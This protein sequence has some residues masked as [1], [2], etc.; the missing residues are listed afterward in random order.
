LKFHK[1][2]INNQYNSPRIAI[3]NSILMKMDGVAP[4]DSRRRPDMRLMENGDWD[5]ANRE[6]SRLE[7]KQRNETRKYLVKSSFKVAR[8]IWFKKTN[9]FHNECV[10]YKYR[11][12]YWKYWSKCP[13]IFT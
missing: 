9:E 10:H 2:G 8:P 1:S 4:T 12:E 3:R 6:K 13:D 7:Q 5:A 11:G